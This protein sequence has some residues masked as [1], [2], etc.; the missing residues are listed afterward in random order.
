MTKNFKAYIKLNKSK[1]Q[2]QYVVIIN[3][4]VIE[5]GK[6]IENMLTKARKKYPDKTP[7]VAKIPDERTLVL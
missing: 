3:G 4:K 2:N 7:F 5:K 6:N 1:L